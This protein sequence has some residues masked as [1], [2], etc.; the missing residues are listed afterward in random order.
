MPLGVGVGVVMGNRDGGDGGDVREGEE[1]GVSLPL[2]E[3]VDAVAERKDGRAPTLS[4]HLRDRQTD[5]QTD[6]PSLSSYISDG[7]S[8]DNTD[9]A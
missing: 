3:V 8:V 7:I 1:E 2:L 6:T 5:R 4:M 9:T